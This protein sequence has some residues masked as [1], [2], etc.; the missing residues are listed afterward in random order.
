M[1]VGGQTVPADYGR[2]SRAHLAVRNGVG[3]TERPADVVIITG[4]D[5]VAFVDNAV[6]NR[7]EESP[8]T[9]RLALLLTPKGRIRTE[10]YVYTA[11]D[12]L[13]LVLPPGTASTLL[14]D[15]REKVFIQDVHFENATGDY[16][17]LGVHGP[18]ATEKLASVVPNVAVP[19]GSFRFV[20]ATIADAGVS[21]IPTDAPC[22]EESYEVV[23]AAYDA[24]VVM[25][26]LVNRGYNAVP[27][28]HTSWETLTL[29]AGTPLFADVEDRI[30]NVVGLRNALDFEKGCYVGQEVVARLENLGQSNDRVVGLELDSVPHRGAVVRADDSSVGEMLRAAKTPSVDGPVALALVSTDAPEKLVVGD[31]IEATRRSLPFVEGSARS[32]RLPEYPSP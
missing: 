31:G 24:D 1:E 17:I 15:W 4:D 10:M 9:G 25:D 27:F 7:V 26:A 6:S 22:G 21:L 2:P 5:R 14:E 8:G 16:T 28:G 3:V 19:E 13:L 29:E 12:R 11:K 20:Q 30:P 23:C 18:R 32:L